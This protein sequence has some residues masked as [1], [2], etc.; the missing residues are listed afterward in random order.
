[1]ETKRVYF[2]HNATSPVLPEVLEAMLP[3]FNTSYGNPSSAH[4]FGREARE[5]VDR[6]RERV[7]ALLNADPGEIVF[8]GGGSESDNLALKGYLDAQNGDPR[9][10]VT[11]AVEHHAVVNSVDRLEELGHDVDY[12][13][14]DDRGNLD[15]KEL[16]ETIG[17]NTAI[18]SFMYANNETGVIFDIP[19]ISSILK[20]NGVVFHTDAVQA[21]GKIPIDVKKDGIDLL[22]ISG[23]KMGAPKGV[24][25]L[26]VKKGIRLVPL[27]HGGHH[28]SGMRAGTENVPSI[29]GL[30]MAAEISRMRLSEEMKRLSGLRDRLESGVLNTVPDV[31]VNGNGSPRLP[32]TT[33]L[34]FHYVEGEGI[35]L[36]LDLEGIAVSSGSACTAGDLKVS[37]VLSAMHIDAVVAQGSI[38]FSLGPDTTEDDVDYVLSK[39]P[40]II[41]RLRAMSPLSPGK[42]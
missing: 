19:R 37:H 30:G 1:M 3:Y 20:K 27:I 12:I 23:H 11:S 16:E 40:P 14:V 41:E 21:A 17:E 36:G 25:I 39:L 2:D 5:A 31:S 34:S 18:A 29:V 9:H 10:I 15:V 28:E 22:S 4:R 38:R 24:G 33:N 26:F 13:G 32:N 35:L 7:A 8:T 6:A 42:K